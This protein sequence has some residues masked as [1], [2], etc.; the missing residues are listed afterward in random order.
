M[1]EHPGE[2]NPLFKIINPTTQHACAQSYVDNYDLSSQQQ[3]NT[4]HNATS[5]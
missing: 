3:I 2:E 5:R 1:N 4:S